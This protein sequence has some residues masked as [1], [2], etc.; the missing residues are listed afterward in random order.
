MSEQVTTCAEGPCARCPWRQS[1]RGKES[2][3]VE[4]HRYRWYSRANR[5][6]LWRGLRDGERMTCHPTDSRHPTI[7][8]KPIPDTVQTREC[9]GALILVQRE[10]MIA[11][12]IP[13][14]GFRRYRRE[15][16][17]GLTIAGMRCIVERVLFARLSTN[18]M[19]RPNLDDADIQF[20]PLG[21]WPGN[22]PEATQ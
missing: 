2:P 18:P 4:D 16:P 21:Q 20:E 17:R 10:M 19:G 7:D 6:R 8:G 13:D 5:N 15:R 14:K 1:N 9:A 22:M 12:A 11:Q 3:L